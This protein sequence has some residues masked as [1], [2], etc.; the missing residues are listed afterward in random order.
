MSV[1]GLLL[2]AGNSTRMGE[3]NKLLQCVDAQPMLATVI[4]ELIKSSLDSVWVVT[5]FQADIITALIEQLVSNNDFSAAKNVHCIENLDYL[6]GLSTS[7]KCGIQALPSS[8]EAVMIV[9]ADMPTLTVAHFEKLL[10]AYHLSVAEK[11]STSAKSEQG[12]G[13]YIIAPY[14]RGRRGNPVIF[15]RHFFVALQTIS[16]DRGARQLL[17][18]WA[19][20]II[21]VEMDDDAVLIDIDNAAQLQTARLGINKGASL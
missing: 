11:N 13:R 6:Q 20:Q 5:G 4:T 17:K 15:S 16:G 9:Q 2:A 21:A 12:E 19:D 8:V 18:Q 10:S 7:L 1:A 14:Y 3:A